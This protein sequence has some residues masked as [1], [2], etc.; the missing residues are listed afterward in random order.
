M[1]IISIFLILICVISAINGYRRGFTK[2]AVSMISFLVIVLL[3]S[4]L[5]PLLT[6]IVDNYTDIGEKIEVYCMDALDGKL[7]ESD[8]LGRNEQIALIEKLP[9][10]ETI[11]EDLIENNNHVIYEMLGTVSF[12]GYI[13]AYLVKMILRAIVFLIS[14]VL[15]WVIVK[16]VILCLNGVSRMPV[17]GFFN[18][19][20]GFAIGLVS[21][22]LIVWMLFLVITIFSGTEPAAY[23]LQMIQQDTLA[24]L[25][26]Q[27]NPLVWLIILFLIM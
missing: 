2:T 3:A 25:I 18:K 5:N 4:I 19:M 8:D 20:G 11:R 1:G 7:T 10:P 24:N 14:I 6:N 17:I 21:G 26:Y 16:I 23:A 13:A 12:L 22:L 9:V 27:K 15:A